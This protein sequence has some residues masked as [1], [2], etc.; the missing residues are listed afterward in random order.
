M[1]CE[2][3]GQAIGEQRYREQSTSVPEVYLE[4]L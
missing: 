3:L 2:L 1:L 4:V